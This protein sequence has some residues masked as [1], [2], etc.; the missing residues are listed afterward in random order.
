MTSSETKQQRRL[1]EENLQS[2][3]N[4]FGKDGRE[5]FRLKET[6]T[7]ELQK[8][9]NQIN[10]IENEHG[11][12][13]LEGIKSKFSSQ[14]VRRYD[15]AWNWARQDSYTFYNMCLDLYRKY[16]LS[17]NANHATSSINVNVSKLIH[18]LIRIKNR[19]TTSARTC[20]KQCFLSK[21]KHFVALSSSSPSLSNSSLATLSL[22][23]YI[24]DLLLHH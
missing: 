10:E 24:Y 12:F 3:L 23:D 8:L 2:L 11:E 18:Y 1:L 7:L 17:E 14:K 15:S 9:Q 22:H 20:L 13:Y 16:L 6:T 21:K 4:Y 19:L 5:G